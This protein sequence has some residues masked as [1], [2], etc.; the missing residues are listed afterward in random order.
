MISFM[1]NNIPDA[2]LQIIL[3]GLLENW[4]NEVI[5]FKE[6]GKD[7]DKGK[8]GHYFSAISNEANLR[9]LQFGW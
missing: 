7:Y 1:S 2:D 8:I 5:E 4:E 6:A 3:N 9:G